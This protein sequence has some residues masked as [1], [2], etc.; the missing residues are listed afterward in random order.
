MI[1]SNVL[2]RYSLHLYRSLFDAAGDAII[3]CS[4]QGL[5]IE[6]NQATLALFAC[7]REQIIG[8]S[9]TNWSPE[10]QPE[11]RRSDEMAPEI[12]ARARAGEVVRFE[13]ENL[14]SDGKP[15]PVDVT[16]RFARME[17]DEIFVVISR[18]ISDRKMTEMAL[19][20]SEGRWKFAIEGSGDGLWDWNIQT[21]VAYYSP[22][23]KE[24]FGYV[25][26]DFGTTSEEWS[27]RIHPDDAPGVFAA[28]QPY[29]EGK[30][31]FASIEFRML[32][33]DA[34]WK[35]TLGRGMVV[36]R[37]SDGN[38]LRMI[39][40]NTDITE[41][42]Q[43]E[44]EL[45]AAKR[46]A[47]SASLTKSHFLA[48]ASHDLRQPM[49]AINLFTEAL[50]RTDLS[51]EQKRISDY[52]SQS[53]QS[54][55]DL[56]NTLLD[57]SK[58]DAGEVRAS[59]SAIT[60]ETL[61]RTIDAEFSPIALGKSLRFKLSFPL[62]KMLLMVDGKLLMSLL[63]NLIGN[64]LKYTR[65][66]GV[67]V[68]IR[69]RGHQALLQ[70]WDTGIGIAPEHLNA[71]YEEY[72]QI[73]NPE[74]DRAKGLGL[75]LSI[76]KR[77]AKLLETDV[78][79]RS[80]PGKGS[81]FEFRLP[82]ISAGERPMP[83]RTGPS[84]IT[85]EARH[86]SRHVVLVED[87]LMVGTATKLALEAIGMTVARYKTAEEAL[88]DP[89]IAA[90]DFYISD[91]R[92]PGLSGVEFLDAVQQKASK[93]I[94]AVIVTGDMAVSRIDAMRSTSWPVLFKPVDLSSL[95]TAIEAQDLVHRAS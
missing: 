80:R 21:G 13:W 33:K 55:G 45:I 28:I 81:V 87:D 83:G 85:G 54:L 43:A 65:Q 42:K 56:L 34:S 6:C 30:P 79:C 52:L 63:G 90:A 36:S 49:Q 19:Q 94:K 20:E 95:L 17:G 53:T 62:G 8:T 68:A 75:G 73:G 61:F 46:A 16:V 12:F 31:G 78:V 72:F 93:P 7:A 58:L 82:L 24:M 22:R 77:I 38:P 11:G 74:R 64:A 41:R 40:T 44:A 14:R 1:E 5:V 26:A 92:L 3:V 50:A 66:G 2:E 67:L 76:V 15:L 48:A 71:I 59:P 18:D 35:W 27:K 47:E 70:V 4:A 25:D 60:V 29:M 23:Y 10:F 51:A 89:A 57:I 84:A 39:G 91:L 69:R 88:A 9:P 86:A 32:C 37:D